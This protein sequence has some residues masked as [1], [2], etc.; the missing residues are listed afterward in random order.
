MQN[1]RKKV[2]IRGYYVFILVFL[3]LKVDENKVSYGIKPFRYIVERV[4]QTSSTTTATTTVRSSSKCN[5]VLPL[6]RMC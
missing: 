5:F 6:R 3:S 1:L 2:V 4:R